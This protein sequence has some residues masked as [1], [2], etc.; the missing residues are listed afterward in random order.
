[1]EAAAEAAGVFA[2]AE[3]AGMINYF[4]SPRK[5]TSMPDLHAKVGSTK[6]S[7]EEESGYPYSPFPILY[8]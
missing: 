3:A 7:S 6:E 2:F 1:V 8:V 5:S 4:V